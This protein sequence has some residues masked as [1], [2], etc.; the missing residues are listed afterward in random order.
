MC[1][2]NLMC[3]LLIFSLV[4]H[5]PFKLLISEV[6]MII[7]TLVCCISPAIDGNA[8]NNILFHNFLPFSK[9]IRYGN[10]I[11]DYMLQVLEEWIAC[12]PGSHIVPLERTFVHNLNEAG[13]TSSTRTKSE[14]APQT[15]THTPQTRYLQ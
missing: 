9:R 5:L 4:F 12:S 6:P 10:D 1:I 3:V 8:P 13:H 14:T 15:H 11:L 7:L 2:N